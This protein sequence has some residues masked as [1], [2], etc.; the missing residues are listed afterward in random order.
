MSSQHHRCTGQAL[1]R[2]S[3][4]PSAQASNCACT[5]DRGTRCPPAAATLCQ[6]QS[7]KAWITTHC[8]AF[9]PNRHSVCILPTLDLN[10]NPPDVALWICNS[11]SVPYVGVRLLRR[12]EV[13]QDGHRVVNAFVVEPTH[14]IKHGYYILEYQYKSSIIRSWLTFP[15]TL[16]LSHPRL[17][18][19]WC[20]ACSTRKWVCM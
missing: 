15:Q 8:G 17:S 18:N 5:T 20:F 11:T 4:P 13:A 10:H 3:N 16:W 12:S 7:T 6:Y 19:P 14:P 1:G 2:H 9:I